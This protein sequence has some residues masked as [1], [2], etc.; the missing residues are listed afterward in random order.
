MGGAEGPAQVVMGDAYDK[1]RSNGL[2]HI[3]AVKSIAGEWLRLNPQMSPSDVTQDIEAR[4]NSVHEQTGVQVPSD[5]HLSSV[6]HE[7]L[8][9]ELEAQFTRESAEQAKEASVGAHIL[10]GEFPE[11]ARDQLQAVRDLVNRDGSLFPVGNPSPQ[12]GTR[13]LAK[14]ALGNLTPL[15]TE[16]LN[17]V[18]GVGSAVLGEYRERL[19]VM[20]NEEG[21]FQIRQAEMDR[22]GE[23]CDAMNTESK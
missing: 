14:D 13:F 12:D 21:P 7:Q 20:F 8:L 22:A 3:E 5:A 9:A 16:H 4:I 1:L 18:I 17:A 19:A 11:F 10:S 23:A 6:E 2:S 15:G